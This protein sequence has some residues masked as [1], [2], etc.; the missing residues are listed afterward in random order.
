MLTFIK[1]NILDN[2][3]VIKNRMTAFAKLSMQDLPFNEFRL[4]RKNRD[5]KGCPYFGELVFIKNE[6]R[7]VKVFFSPIFQHS[8]LDELSVGGN[9]E[10]YVNALLVKDKNYVIYVFDKY[11]DE[12][13]CYPVDENDR[14][15]HYDLVIA[16]DGEYAL[17][18]EA[19]P[20]FIYN[21]TESSETLKALGL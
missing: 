19:R 2:A 14:E 17:D 1:N 16:K 12:Y 8:I 18:T 3:R 13:N 21:Y 9:Y 11:N 7:A 20:R 10:S 15:L 6:Y 5:Y 4:I